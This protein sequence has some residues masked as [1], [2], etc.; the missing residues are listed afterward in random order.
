[1]KAAIP[2]LA[3]EEA[4]MTAKLTRREK[5]AAGRHTPI[6]AQDANH[7]VRRDICRYCRRPIMRTQATR[8]WFLATVLA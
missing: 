8:I 6:A 2:P 3:I 7:E 5:C 1:V 4:P